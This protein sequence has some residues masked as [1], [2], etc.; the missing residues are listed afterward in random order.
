MK[1]DNIIVAK[2]KPIKE[3][4]P[5]IPAGIILIQVKQD[6]LGNLIVSDKDDNEYFIQFE[7]DKE[8]FFEYV[9]FDARDEGYENSDDMCFM[10][11]LGE[12]EKGWSMTFR[13]GMDTWNE[14]LNIQ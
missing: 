11:A 1:L 4:K 2:V 3:K 8:S 7:S 6:S 5:A 13:I 10:D 14:L 12:I 9:V